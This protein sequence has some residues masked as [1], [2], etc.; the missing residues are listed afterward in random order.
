VTDPSNAIPN[1]PVHIVVTS[2]GSEMILY[3]N[4][5]EVNR[6]S[7][8]SAA[9]ISWGAGQIGIGGN[10]I[11]GG[12]RR[13]VGNV[14]QVALYDNVIDPSTILSHYQAGLPSS[15]YRVLILSDNPLLYYRLNDINTTMVDQMR[16]LDLTITGTPTTQQPG[17]IA[18]DV[19]NCMGFTTSEYGR[20]T[21]V[22]GEKSDQGAVEAWINITSYAS[23]RYVC[24]FGDNSSASYFIGPMRIGTNGRIG[25]YSTDSSEYRHVESNT[26]L[27]TGEWYHIVSQSTGSEYEIYINGVKETLIVVD[28]P[29]D[30]HWTLDI[31]NIDNFCIGGMY[32]NSSF[33]TGFNG[34]IDEL[35]VYDYALTAQ[36]AL[37]HYNAGA[38]YADK[39]VADGGTSFYN[40]SEGS[41]APT[42]V[43]S[44]GGKNL[45]FSGT[46]STEDVTPPNDQFNAIWF[47]P[48]ARLATPYNDAANRILSPDMIYTAEWLVRCRTVPNTS[49]FSLFIQTAREINQ[50]AYYNTGY[51]HQAQGGYGWCDETNTDDRHYGVMSPQPTHNPL[52]WH[53]L[54]IRSKSPGINDASPS[55]IEFFIDGEPT[56]TF[57]R[58]T[59]INPNVYGPPS[60]TTLLWRDYD[61]GT[62][63]EEGIEIASVAFYD[64]VE[65]TDQQILDH[66]NATGISN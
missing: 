6:Q 54:T 42:Y 23:T 53:L 34:L 49:Y 37:D 3:R 48:G 60:R 9:A 15:N 10:P 27:N 44:I 61:D 11:S 56:G 33:G 63:N 17:A 21:L 46:D 57:I 2:D 22:G 43:D 5:I 19:N 66:Y 40:F 8:G 28:G 1:D 41:S 38:T 45:T 31:G 30:G 16:L 14:G 25:L 4:G 50:N 29:N 47:N 55:A 58:T 32:R 24:A 35:A 64:N 26:A 7:Q 20:K 36:Q 39:V 13:L 59:S 51:Y 52:E 12:T 18:G 65:L 62:D